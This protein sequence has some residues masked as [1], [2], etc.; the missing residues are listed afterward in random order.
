M[1]QG[2]AATVSDIREVHDAVR[3][4][5]QR[6]RELSRMTR[7]ELIDYIVNVEDNLAALSARIDAYTD[8]P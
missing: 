5:L 2:S 7:G 8:E 6:R 1:D 3:T 4:N